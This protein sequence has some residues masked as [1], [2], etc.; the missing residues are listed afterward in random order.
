VLNAPTPYLYAEEDDLA[1][2][3]LHFG[4]LSKRLKTKAL[5]N[6]VNLA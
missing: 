5:S 4:E 1:E 3:I 2:I 6:M